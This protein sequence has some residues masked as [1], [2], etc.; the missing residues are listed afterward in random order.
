MAVI[1]QKAMAAFA[2]RIIIINVFSHN[3]RFLSILYLF[4]TSKFMSDLIL[5]AAI[6][7]T[8]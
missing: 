1:D 3:I 7:F 6:I 8:Y 4:Y 2:Q 5:K